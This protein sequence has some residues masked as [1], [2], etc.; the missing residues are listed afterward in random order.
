MTIPKTLIICQSVHHSNTMKVAKNMAKEL[1]ADI[2]NPSEVTAKDFED[3]DLIGFGSGIYD[4]KHHTS[5]FKLLN[6]LTLQHNK[7]AFI[8]STATICY[9]KM[10]EPLRLLLISK[11]FYVVDEFIC[12]GFMDY[13]FLKYF[14]GGINK[15]RPNQKDLESAREFAIKLKNMIEKT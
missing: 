15:G 7:P 8:F 3:Y 2:K 4:G 11:G 9:K 13:S 6:S 12:R 5:L 1:E 10:H 14:F